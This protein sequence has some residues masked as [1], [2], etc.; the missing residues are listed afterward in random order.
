MTR[1]KIRFEELPPDKLRW[2]CCDDTI[3]V[4]SS[5]EARP[6]EEI[7][8]QER[9]LRAIQT[10][11]DIKSLGYNVFITGMVGTG[12][13]TTVKQLLERLEKGDRT[14][15]D[16]LYVNNF[17]YPDEP[18]L[19]VLPAGQGREFSEAMAR[20][21]DALSA[22]IPA[23]LKSPYYAERRDGIVE[24]QQKKQRDILQRFEEEVA[25][26]GFSVVQ[27]QMGLFTRP[28]LIPMVDGQPTPFAKIEGLVKEKK[29]PK[30]KLES[31]RAQYEELSAKLESVFE[32]LK[33]IDEQTRE[34]LRSWDEESISPMIKSGIDEVRARFA[35]PKIDAYLDEVE[36]ALVKAID[37]FKVQKKEDK[38]K[39]K[40]RDKA[41]DFLEYRVNLLVDNSDQHGAPVVMETNPTYVN[42][43]GSIEA[44]YSRVGM[45]QTDFTMIKAG[46]FLKANGG[47]LVLNALDALVEPGVWA[48][49]KRTLRNQVF[50]IQNYLQM[51]LFTSARLKPE[52]IQPDV[53]VVMIGDASIYNL[54]YHM[55]EDFKKIFKIKAEFDSEMD[56]GEKAIGDYVRFV[57]KICDDDRLRP[58]DKSGLAAL[59]EYATRIAGRQR[60]LS[61][62]FHVIAD[63]IRESSYWAG[64]MKKTEVGRD[65]VEK[66][67]R[68]RFE[69]VS[70]IEDKIQE[71]IEEGTILIDTAGAVV[72]QVNGL[73]VYDMGQFMFGKPARITA[74]TAMGRA[75][76]INIEREAD[77]S[78]PTHNKGVLILGGYLRGKYASKQ[79]LS[80]TASLA[81]EQSYG[82][83]DG[84]SASSTEVYAILSSLSGLALRQDLAVTGSLNQK[85]EIQPIG[86][87]N[88]KIE[89]FFDVCKAKGL[90][91][92]Q[93]V[94]IPHQNV[95]NLMLRADV[96]AAV[97][98]GT[99]HVY[100]VRTIDE[101]IEILTGVEAGAADKDGNYPEG[102]VHFLVDRELQRL[103]RG[104]KAFAA[105]GDKGESP[106]E[107]PK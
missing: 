4:S 72:G 50:E 81:F 80:L 10:G 65:D 5:A 12:R 91:G 49:L 102:T 20:L 55:D 63:V 6:C 59:V 87:V 41:D 90:T 35:F 98:E 16:I 95:Q 47:Y 7:I 84:D 27:V 69:R 64:R 39:E 31:L 37:A 58:F 15:D 93:G 107:G 85:G 8:G 103:A 57:R 2:V 30:E 9:A 25:E 45:G 22:N 13:T 92:T 18:V 77:L 61:T 24:A 23:L 75:G 11:L 3:P 26:Q 33:E 74:R 105:P 46:S 94:L 88:E 82:G 86:G 56:K 79:P 106:I 48:T 28:D 32:S 101:G 52:S 19:V 34:M 67:I 68:E 104:W 62:R 44:T 17:K 83:V 42:L 38:D 29:I 71:M 73:S 43:F 53:K 51:Y 97:K 66:S 76:V 100:P 70:L 89:G 60:K 96:V 1:A 99:F 21:I 54:L 14:P 40:D 36:K 78:G